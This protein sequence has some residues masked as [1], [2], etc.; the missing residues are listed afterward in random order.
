MSVCRISTGSKYAARLKSSEKTDRIP[1]VFLSGLDDLADKIRGF[2]SGGVDYITKP[3]QA[4]E[5]LARVQTHLELYRLRRQIENRNLTLDAVVQ[6]RTQELIGIMESLVRE[7]NAAGEGR[8][9][10]GGETALRATAVGHLCT[11]H[12]CFT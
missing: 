12:Q 9:G 4:A 5:V 6:E 1:V 2:E 10:P 7:I 11:G 8:G 3:F